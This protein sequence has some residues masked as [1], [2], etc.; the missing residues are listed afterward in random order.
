MTRLMK[1]DWYYSLSDIEFLDCSGKPSIMEAIHES[2]QRLKRLMTERKAIENKIQDLQ[3][4]E[5]YVII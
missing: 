4:Q 1:N 3:E 5:K 2:K